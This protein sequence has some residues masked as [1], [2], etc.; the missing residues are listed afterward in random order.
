MTTE[1][2]INEVF[3]DEEVKYVRFLS[4]DSVVVVYDD[5]SEACLVRSQNGWRFAED[6]D[7]A[8][9]GGSVLTG[10]EI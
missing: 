10:R 9:D 8:V 1:Q 6:R 3:L 5:L 4:N 7:P 2:M